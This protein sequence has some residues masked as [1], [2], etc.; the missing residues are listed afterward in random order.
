MAFVFQPPPLSTSPSSTTKEVTLDEVVLQAESTADYDLA[1]QNHAWYEGWL[2]EDRLLQQ[3]DVCTVPSSDT[4]HKFVV[5]MTS[6]VLRGYVRKGS[7]HVSLAANDTSLHDVSIP[8]DATDTSEDLFEIDEDFF[9]NAMLASSAHQMK[10]RSVCTV[11][12]C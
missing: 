12:S 2:S 7:T 6:P 3:G 10:V 1:A 9:G 8:S 11:W 4:T 5:L